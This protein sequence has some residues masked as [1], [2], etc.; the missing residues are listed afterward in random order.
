ME[1]VKYCSIQQIIIE[2]RF[3]PNSWSPTPCFKR[4]LS[5]FI[6]DRTEDMTQY[7]KL[8]LKYTTV[9]IAGPCLTLS[10]WYRLEFCCR[11]IHSE[12][13]AKQRT[14]TGVQHRR[15][16]WPHSLEGRPI[17]MWVLDKSVPR[18][19]LIGSMALALVSV[20]WGWWRP[21]IHIMMKLVCFCNSRVLCPS[22]C[23]H[24]VKAIGVQ[25]HFTTC[26]M[27]VTTLLPDVSKEMR[28][29]T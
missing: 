24:N 27:T 29:T 7:V 9:L 19:H 20:L 1:W 26:F 15:R 14:R 5:G 21:S 18:G 2:V 23:I 6:V 17:R 16:K 3:S 13:C 28:I 4:S 12:E 11:Y 8:N 25:H 22:Y 10:F